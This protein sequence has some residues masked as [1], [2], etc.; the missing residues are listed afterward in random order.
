[1]V[2][3]TYS[4]IVYHCT[5]RRSRGASNPVE[6]A[7]AVNER[8]ELLAVIGITADQSPQS[9]MALENSPPNVTPNAFDD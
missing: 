2:E 6:P 4:P 9:L 1:V 5:I 8:A 7:D 3:Q